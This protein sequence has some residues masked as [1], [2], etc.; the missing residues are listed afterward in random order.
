MARYFGLRGSALN[1]AIALLV[2]WPAF[3]CYAYNLA[4][5]GGLLTL[6]SFITTFPQLDTITT[7]GHQQYLNSQIQGKRPRRARPL[8]HA[9]FPL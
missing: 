3:G 6:T 4:V 9:L 5:M 8:I 7:T 2:V 1:K